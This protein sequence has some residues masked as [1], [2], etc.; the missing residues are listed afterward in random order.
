LRF[1]KKNQ[2]ELNPDQEQALMAKNVTITESTAVPTKKIHVPAK[3]VLRRHIL[4][5]SSAREGNHGRLPRFHKLSKISSRNISNPRKL[6]NS[7]FA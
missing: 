3:M 6:T 2:S 7:S 4:L 5:N 1:K